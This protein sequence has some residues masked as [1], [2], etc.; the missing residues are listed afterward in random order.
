MKRVVAKF[1]PKLLTE[2]QKQL[3]IGVSQDMLDSINSDFDFINTIITGL[4]SAGFQI[5]EDIQAKHLSERDFLG[6]FPTMAALLG[7]V[8]MRVIKF[9]ALQI[10]LFFHPEAG[11][12]SNRDRIYARKQ[13]SSIFPST[14]IAFCHITCLTNN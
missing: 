13:Y 11:Y 1:V 5:R 4:M 2:E 3:H 9:P 8:C 10:C 6:M 7:E 12:F 14:T